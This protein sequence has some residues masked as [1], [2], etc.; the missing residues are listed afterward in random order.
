MKLQDRFWQYVDKRSD[1]ECWPWLASKREFGYGWFRISN[2][3]YNAHRVSWALAHKVDLKTISRDVCILHI[4]DN[5]PCVNPNHLREGDRKQN[6]AD[7]VEKRRQ[8]RPLGE[9]NPK[10]KLTWE[11]IHKIRKLR[12]Y[13]TRKQLALLFEVS[14]SNIGYICGGKNWIIN[15]SP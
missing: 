10:A 6:I 7:M 1:I 13:L 2:R 14:G 5:P 11:H 9:K 12:A 15:T 3:M 8:Y 4:C